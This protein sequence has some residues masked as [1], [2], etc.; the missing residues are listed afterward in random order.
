MTLAQRIRKLE[1][2]HA[3]TPNDGVI[4]MTRVSPDGS[5]WPCTAH[6]VGNSTRVQRDP[7]EPEDAFHERVGAVYRELTGRNPEWN[8]KK[9]P[10]NAA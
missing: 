8:H 3:S 6:F 2:K 7:D 5:A 10:T 4:L 9:D 1:A